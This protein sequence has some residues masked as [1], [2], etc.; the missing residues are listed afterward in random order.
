MT[1][2]VAELNNER[3]QREG[4][5][6]SLCPRHYSQ[7]RNYGHIR[8]IQ[9]LTGHGLTADA[10][11]ARFIKTGGHDRQCWEWSG[12]TTKGG[13]GTFDHDT[14]HNAHKW[15]WERFVSKVPAGYQLDHICR[16][17]RC[18]RPSHLQLV[19]VGKHSELGV[20]QRKL[21]KNNPG[22]DL[23]GGNRKARTFRE[24]TFA[25][26]HNLPSTMHGARLATV[27]Q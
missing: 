7:V 16:N 12:A 25:V 27:G 1:Q 2:C 13:Y 14:T 21:A 6:K 19:T 15:A 20:D 18:V 3:C 10:R 24:L 22:H 23:V 5:V 4:K 8:S 11:F 17:R 26:T 9:P